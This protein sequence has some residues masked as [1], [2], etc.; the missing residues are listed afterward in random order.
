[1]AEALQQAPGKRHV[2]VS[3]PA[4]NV[5]AGCISLERALLDSPPRAKAAPR[6]DGDLATILYTSGTTGQ[7]K[8]VMQT[9]RNLYANSMNSWRTAGER[10]RSPRS[11][12]VLP[13]AHSF[14]LGLLI[15]GYLF[16]GMG[17]LMRWF[18]PK[19]ALALIAQHRLVG[20]A[21][22]PTM[23]LYLLAEP[24]AGNFETSSMERWLVG[25]APMAPE[26]IAEFEQKF[27]GRVLVGY[28]LTEA[29]PAIS[30]ERDEWP[31]KLGSV[32]V[33]ME[34][35]RVKIVD[36]TGNELP[37][38]E[39]GEI[40]AAGENISPGYYELPDATRDTF[41]DGW[42]HTGD[43]GYLDED[44]YLFIVDRKKDL[45]IRAGLNVYPKDVEEVLQQHPAVSEVAVVGV[46]DAL[47]GEEVCA[48][49]VKKYGTEIGADE[50]VLHCQAH[51]AKY[52][53][54]RHLEIVGSLPKNNLGKVQKTE[55]RARALRKWGKS[56]SA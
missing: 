22:V 11:L 24:D 27:P 50:L 49:V 46:D 18:A 14:G 44:G 12:I 21:G 15:S 25:A 37:R 43:I 31:R 26:Q 56:S 20:M 3:G 5:P 30:V 6:E 23:F 53:T 13:L 9:H 40:G 10:N 42:L 19:E 34:G 2:F 45:I 29:C 35:V 32:G 38:G 4:E 41:R 36:E 47:M 7:P 48:F 55:L 8:G 1:V 28:G 52:K 39:R 54:P 33:P 16:G 51:L 17:V